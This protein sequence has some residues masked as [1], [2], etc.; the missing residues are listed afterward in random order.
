MDAEIKALKDEVKSKFPSVNGS[1]MVFV[2]G[3]HDNAGTKSLSKSGANDSK[4]YG[5]FVIHESD[6]MW[7]NKYEGVIKSTAEKLD[8]YLKEKS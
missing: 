8:A 3:N 2:K 1:D 4:H 6:Y 7:Y 5:V